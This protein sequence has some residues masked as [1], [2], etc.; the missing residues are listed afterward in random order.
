MAM[1]YWAFRAFSIKGH[2]KPECQPRRFTRLRWEVGP[3]LDL[4]PNKAPSQVF[5]FPCQ[6]CYDKRLCHCAV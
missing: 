5:D 3:L 4:H 1:S 2:A 6:A